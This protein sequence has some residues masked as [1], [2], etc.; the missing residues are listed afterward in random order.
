MTTLVNLFHYEQSL[1][2][3]MLLDF[4]YVIVQKYILCI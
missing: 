2:L 4:L 3:Q 1:K